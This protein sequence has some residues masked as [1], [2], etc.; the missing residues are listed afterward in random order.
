MPKPRVPLEAVLFDWDG[1]L[2]DS[3]SALLGAWHATTHEVL[4][5]RRPS[6][7][8]EEELVFTLPGCSSSRA[9]RA[10]PARRTGSATRAPRSSR[11]TPAN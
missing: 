9:W 7:A 8:Q 6:T 4:G 10:T 5:R 11:G 3:R 2:L 1:T